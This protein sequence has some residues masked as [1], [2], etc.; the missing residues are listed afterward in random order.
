DRTRADVFEAQLAVFA[1]RFPADRTD[2]AQAAR[3]LEGEDRQEVRLLE[4]DMDL[5][6]GGR[7]SRV[8]VGDVE[9]AGIAPTGET[10]REHVP[11]GRTRAVAAGEGGRLTEFLR[12][13]R[14]L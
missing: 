5:A 10:R 4:I 6:V 11:D 8:H 3:A 1:V 13:V 7:P 14:S 2:Q 9:H 12:A